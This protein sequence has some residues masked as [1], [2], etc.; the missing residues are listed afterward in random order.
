MIRRILVALDDSPRAP[1]VFRRA[2]ELAQ[3]AGAELIIG[4]HGY[5]GIDR[6][7]GTTAGHVV[8]HAKRDVFIVYR[9]G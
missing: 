2:V 6:V 7:L 9:G 8:H 4:N 5:R 1:R 3:G